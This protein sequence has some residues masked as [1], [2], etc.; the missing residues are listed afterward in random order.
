MERF[1]II[2]K[3]GAG[4]FGEAFRAWDS[5]QG[6]P[7]VLKRPLPQ[8]VKRPDVLERFDREIARLLELKHPNIVPIIDHGHDGGL[9]YL[10]MRFLPGGS[11]F[12]R[13]RP[14][15]AT[16][17]HRWLPGIAAALDHAH[18]HGILHRD[19][20]PANIFFD[21]RSSAYLGDFGI[22]KIIDEDLAQESEHSLTSTGGEIGTYPYMGPEFFRKP[23]ALSGAYDQYALAITVFEMV[24]GRRPFLGDSG[25]LIASHLTERPPGLLAIAQDVP[26]SLAAAVS[27]ALSK[28]P[29][30]RFATCCEFANAALCDVLAP[31][32]G[33][34]YQLLC[35]ACHAL[36][37]VPED[38]KGRACRCPH[39][40]EE[41]LVAKSLDA[42][43][44]REEHAGTGAQPRNQQSGSA[45]SRSTP[46]LR[47]TATD[48]PASETRAAMS[49]RVLKGLAIGIPLV[50]LVCLALLATLRHDLTPRK[51]HTP[52]A[53]VVRIDPPDDSTLPKPAHKETTKAANGPNRIPASPT[54]GLPDAAATEAPKNSTHNPFIAE[55][56][57]DGRET[58]LYRKSVVISHTAIVVEDGQPR[59]V[60][61]F[62][63]LF[64]L[65]AAGTRDGG[66]IYVG[67]RAGKPAGWI[68]EK[69]VVPWATRFLFR[70]WE[71]IEVFEESSGATRGQSLIF[72]P[73]NMPAA[74]IAVAL[75]NGKPLNDEGASFPITFFSVFLSQDASQRN[76]GV[77]KIPGSEKSIPP[78]KP[79]KGF[80]RDV[81]MSGEPWKPVILVSRQELI[82]FCSTMDFLLAS[83]LKLQDENDRANVG[84]LVRRLQLTVASLVTGQDFDSSLNVENLVMALPLRTPTLTIDPRAKEREHREQYGE[85]VESLI[86]SKLRCQSIL[87][88]TD[89]WQSSDFV[90]LTLDDIP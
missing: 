31:T 61:P 34:Y 79:L 6:V 12:D 55:L 38:F 69:D 16:L 74:Q 75:L 64:H 3:L 47:L 24:A 15:S 13:P 22:A 77:M 17:L 58:P 26:G 87:N 66:M 90:F 46:D 57:R 30:A 85:W 33:P 82:R 80:V 42:L 40:R 8:H 43:W 4:G 41:L 23:R 10:A 63:I 59:A 37:K 60:E 89:L 14:S 29:E 5:E 28:Q 51:S 45:S 62:S 35:P 39:C 44:R 70:P 32:P 21:A 50:S 83:F 86:A 71:K 56:D 67:D 88:R 25:Q 76:A 65:K 2:S 18:A 20:K 73:R 1:R 36:V 27:N 52:P 72:D 68:N 19:V 84:E 11:L 48:P 7:V 9:P 53:I 49:P 54:H 81:Y 78:L